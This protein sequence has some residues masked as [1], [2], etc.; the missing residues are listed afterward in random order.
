MNIAKGLIGEAAR[1]WEDEEGAHTP[2]GSKTP[3]A[4]CGWLMKMKRAH[5]MFMST[6]SRR[7]F[8]VE[9]G[10]LVWYKSPSA[11]EECGRLPL[12][13]IGAV[14]KFEAGAQGSFSFMVS[15]GG[16]NMLLRGEG[17]NDVARW[18]RGLTLQI[19]LMRGGS[20]QGPPCGKLARR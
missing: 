8:T 13:F 3:I 19:D 2:S 20:I 1:P 11:P 17:A 6:W 10:A 5:R 4:L 14:R 18:V 15:G 12:Q 9:D 7:W 16:R